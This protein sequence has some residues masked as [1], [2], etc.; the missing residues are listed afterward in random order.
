MD[1]IA[2][3]L[4]APVANMME[5]ALRGGVDEQPS[6]DHQ[7]ASGPARCDLRPAID[8]GP[9]AREHR[10]HQPPVRAG[11]EGH[12]PGM[13]WLQR[14]GY[15]RRPRPIRAK[16]LNSSRLQRVGEP[17][18][19]WRGGRHLRAGGLAAGVGYQKSIRTQRR[20]SKTGYYQPP[21]MLLFVLYACLR[22][23][24]DLALSPFRD[25]AADQAE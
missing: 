19:R 16:L 20:S 18:L 9:G 17:S 1:A 11:G 4:V 10:V 15:R 13:G 25:R 14:P 8:A 24:I 5:A 2:P 23:F 7:S 12:Q 22:L 3:E 6:P 21:P